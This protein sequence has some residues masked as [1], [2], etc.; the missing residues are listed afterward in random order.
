[1]V[2]RCS[3]VAFMKPAMRCLFWLFLRRSAAAS[4]LLSGDV[5]TI[6]AVM[7]VEIWINFTAAEHSH[8]IFPLFSMLL[9][10]FLLCSANNASLILLQPSCEVW[11]V[12]IFFAK[13]KIKVSSRWQKS[14]ALSWELSVDLDHRA[15][16]PVPDTDDLCSK[17]ADEKLKL[18]QAKTL[19]LICPVQVVFAF[20]N[21]R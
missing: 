18:Q 7:A 17:S 1:M 20:W 19:C 5:D 9:A 3:V 2:E 16:Y 12:T 4:D 8:I 10:Q 13:S 6:Y 21:Q 15:K 14:C 11:V